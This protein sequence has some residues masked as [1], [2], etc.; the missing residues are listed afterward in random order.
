[1]CY[2][3]FLRGKVKM[4]QRYNV[5]VKLFSTTVASAGLQFVNQLQKQIEKGP[6]D[7]ALLPRQQIKVITILKTWFLKM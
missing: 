7:A 2:V 3:Q 4:H 6:G 5:R 1:M